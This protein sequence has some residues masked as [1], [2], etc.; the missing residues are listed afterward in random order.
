MICLG[1]GSTCPGSSARCP[2][3][4]RTLACFP[5]YVRSNHVAQLQDALRRCQSG[6]VAFA[7]L[8][9][10][11]AR[12]TQLSMA[13]LQQWRG[14]PESRLAEGLMQP[15]ESRYRAGVAELDRSLDLLDEASLLLDQALETE[16]LELLGVADEMLTDFFK[17]GCAGCAM[18]MEELEQ[19]E[20]P[21]QQGTFLDVRG[22]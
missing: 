6:E 1:C 19:L 9:E 13:F 22:L 12:F 3:C 10:T 15:L 16:D 21:E 8:A 14:Q 17:I 18:L 11:Y 5:P 2:Q 4:D 7:E 20:N